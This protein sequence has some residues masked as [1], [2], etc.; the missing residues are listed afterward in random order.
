M[1]FLD[2]QVTWRIALG[3]AI[4]LASVA[5]VVTAGDRGGRRA[6]RRVSAP[7]RRPSRPR[8]A[9]GR[10]RS[11][12]APQELRD[13]ANGPR[14]RSPVVRSLTY[15]ETKRSA[16]AASMPRPNWSAYS[17]ASSRWSSPQAIASRSTAERSPSRSM[18]RR[19]TLTPSGSGGPVSSSHHSP[20]ST[21]LDEPVLAER[22]LTL[23]DQEP[24]RRRGRSRPRPGSARTAARGTANSPST[25]RSVRN[26]V[27][28][29]PGTT[30]SSVRS[31]SSASGSRATTTGP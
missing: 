10:R 20:R 30:I 15:I 25:R 27:V 22:Q 24:D 29:A 7:T 1:V 8:P 5:V 2:E 11:L 21:H 13:R 3:A 4:V 12:A 18:S 31:S 9:S 14:R 28:I 23:V 17:S 16:T 6:V 19:A 26:A